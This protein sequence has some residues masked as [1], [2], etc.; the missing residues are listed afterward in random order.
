M[1]WDLLTG[2]IIVGALFWTVL[3]VLVMRKAGYA[4]WHGL[5]F[6]VPLVNIGLFVW[7]ALTEWPIQKELRLLR[8]HEIT[9]EQ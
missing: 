7:F 1:F 4:G 8:I 6:L 5:L 2:F 3:A 9:P